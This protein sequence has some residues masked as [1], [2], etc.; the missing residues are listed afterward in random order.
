[1]TV[2]DR[3]DA[4]RL[5]KLWESHKN[6]ALL[7]SVSISTIRNLIHLKHKKMNTSEWT[8]YEQEEM[9]IEKKIIKY[10]A[11]VAIINREFVAR[12]TI[13]KMKWDPDPYYNPQ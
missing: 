8:K 3:T 7:F 2:D 9:E 1:M 11:E 6:I 13:P 4:L 10:K 5:M 12:Q